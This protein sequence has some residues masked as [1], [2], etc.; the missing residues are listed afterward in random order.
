MDSKVI[1]VKVA[2]IR[3]KYK[4]LAEWCDDPDNVYIGRRGVVFI[5]KVRYPPTDSIWAN[6]FKISATKTRDQVIS[7][8]QTYIQ[9]KLEKS[10]EL[11]SKLKTLKGKNLGCWC[12]PQPCHGDVLKKLITELLDD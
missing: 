11:Q 1:N 8:Y 3:P 5:D 6:P 9:T 4:N 2:N 7:E 12:A 10:P